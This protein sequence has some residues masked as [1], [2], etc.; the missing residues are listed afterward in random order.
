MTN[1]TL[2]FLYK[3]WQGKISERHVIPIK[4]WF[5]CTEYH[6]EEQWLMKAL[7]IDKNAERDF[8]LIDIIKWITD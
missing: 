2:N 4:I 5:S 8:A 7:D 1:K 3:N 6:K